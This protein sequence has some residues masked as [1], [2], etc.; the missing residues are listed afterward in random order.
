MSEG[1]PKDYWYKNVF[2]HYGKAYG[3]KLVDGGNG[4]QDVK[5]VYA[6]TEQQI[7]GG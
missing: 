6:G 1:P 3:V 2:I 4:I 5:T 7:K